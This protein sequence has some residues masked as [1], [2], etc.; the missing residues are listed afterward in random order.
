MHTHSAY[1]TIHTVLQRELPEAIAFR[2]LLYRACDPIY[3][4]TRDLL[5]GE[6]NAVMICAV[7]L[8]LT[9]HVRFMTSYP[10]IAATCRAASAF[11][12]A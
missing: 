7:S 2:G 4:N 10:I 11:F 12:S 5:T 1:K 9:R 3:A 6:G 8:R